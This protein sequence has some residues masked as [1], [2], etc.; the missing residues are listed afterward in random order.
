MLF[1]YLLNVYIYVVGY[2]CPSMLTMKINNENIT[3]FEFDREEYNLIDEE[4]YGSYDYYKSNINKRNVN[5]FIRQGFTDSNIE[6]KTKLQTAFNSLVN[7]NVKDVIVYDGVV[8]DRLQLLY[9]LKD[10][11]IPLKSALSR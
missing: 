2:I 7:L 8:S 10:V 4:S 3:A 1:R 11:S 6:K 5:L 9:R